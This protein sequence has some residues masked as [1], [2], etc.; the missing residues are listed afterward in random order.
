M[1]TIDYAKQLVDLSTASANNHTTLKPPSGAK[2]G[3]YIRPVSAY[4]GA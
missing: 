4:L 3:G 2:E 1:H